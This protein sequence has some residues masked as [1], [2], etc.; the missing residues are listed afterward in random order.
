M[1]GDP[2][3]E[4][5]RKLLHSFYLDPELAQGLKFIKERDRLGE[6]EQVRQAIKKWLKAK[7]DDVDA[8]SQQQKGAQRRS[9]AL[10]CCKHELWPCG[11]GFGYGTREKA[12]HAA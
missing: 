6:S 2:A 9:G 3:T 10:A 4:S 5:A 1:R 8:H 12:S 11:E 7:G